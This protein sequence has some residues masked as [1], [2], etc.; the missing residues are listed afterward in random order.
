MINLSKSKESYDNLF[1]PNSESEEMGVYACSQGMFDSNND[2]KQ[3]GGYIMNEDAESSEGFKTKTIYASSWNDYF[4]TPEVKNKIKE[5]KAYAEKKNFE[6]VGRSVAEKLKKK[7]F[8]PKIPNVENP[9][10]LEAMGIRVLVT[11]KKI[12]NV[13]IICTYCKVDNSEVGTTQ[14]ILKDKRDKYSVKLLT[15]DIIFH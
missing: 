7:L 9:E 6:I 11:E 1:E 5:I 10:K 14:F 3:I 12:E 8:S 13:P 4:S 15:S 2:Q